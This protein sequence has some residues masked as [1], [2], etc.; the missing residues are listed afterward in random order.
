M[1]CGDMPY[2]PLVEALSGRRAKYLGLDLKDN[3]YDGKPDLFWDGETIP[4]AENSVDCVMAT[5]VFEH[6]PDLKKILAEIFRVLKPEGFLLF[7]V[8]FLWP[9][10]TVPHDAYRYT[11]FTLEKLLGEAGFDSAQLQALGGWDA[12]LAQMLGLWVRRRWSGLVGRILLRPV[13][14]LLFWPVV[15]FLEKIDRP[16]KQFHESSMLTG[17]GG[18][19][20]KPPRRKIKRMALRSE[21]PIICIAHMH[22][23]AYSESFIQAHLTRL[24]ARIRALY[25]GVFPRRQENDRGIVPLPWLLAYRVAQFS[26]SLWGRPAE[27]ALNRLGSSIHNRSLAR[28]LRDNQVDAVLAE[29]GQ[30]GTTVMDACQRAEVPFIVH[31]HGGDAYVRSHLEN[32]G[33]SYRRMF[34]AADAVIAVSR[35]MERQLL[36]LG[37]PRERLHCNVYGVDCS[38]F[39]QNNP[40]ANP[41]VFIAVG[42]FVDKKA[43]HLTL[44]AFKQTVE[45][46]PESRLMMIGDGQLWEA[47]QQLARA[48]NI[49]DRV[50]FLGACSHG[51]VAAYMG[52]ARAF[53]QHSL[54]TGPGDSEGTPVS[55]MEAGAAGLPVVSTR[56]AGIVDVVIHGET[57]FLVDEGDVDSM[58]KYMIS[59]AQEEKLATTLGQNARE[60]ISNYFSM[61]RSIGCLWEIITNVIHSRKRC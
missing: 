27:P 16:P 47:C 32:F 9:L 17:I 54:T 35:D 19:A 41:P 52:Q 21:P 18:K 13:F 49:S 5:E 11:P 51:E 34:Q 40:G 36:T 8:P 58:S 56:H 48:L 24:P 57:G 43:P 22:K 53:V 15:W 30:I 31:F 42:R 26:S 3:L 23:S 37:A 2:K 10:H 44:L 12:S 6:C 39:T 61:E 45:V 38:L 46:C 28:F 25:G 20:V 29:Y 7:T 55:I 4:L 59:L 60:R 50:D 1:G 14:S 33:S